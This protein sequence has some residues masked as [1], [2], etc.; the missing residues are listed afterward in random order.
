MYYL[1]VVFVG[2]QAHDDAGDSTVAE[3]PGRPVGFSGL[4]DYASA[5]DYEG[6][7]SYGLGLAGASGQP[8]I[9]AGELKRPDDAGGFFFV[10]HFDVRTA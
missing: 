5:G 4:R 8:A 6:Y 10:I 3:T 9:R 2:A 7:V 1:S